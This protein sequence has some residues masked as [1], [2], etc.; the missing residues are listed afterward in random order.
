[1]NDRHTLSFNQ[2]IKSSHII[3]ILL[4]IVALIVLSVFSL[5]TIHELN[6]MNE[7]RHI[8][9]S[10]FSGIEQKLT[11]YADSLAIKKELQFHLN[12][13]AQESYLVISLIVFSMG[14]FCIMGFYTYRHFRK[15][16][17]IHFNKALLEELLYY[18][19]L[20]EREKTLPHIPPSIK[21]L[22]LDR[23]SFISECHGALQKNQFV[24][25]YQPIINVM[26]GKIADV[27][28][29]IRWQ[30]P[31]YGVLSPDVFLPLCENSEFII[32]LGQW[33]LKKAFDQIKQWQTLG[34]ST[35][36]M[37]INLSTRQ[38]ID[39]ELPHL[40]QDIISQHAMSPH[41]IKLE[42]TE[43][44]MMKDMSHSIQILN[45]LRNIGIQLSLDD[46]GTGYATL[47]YLKQLPIHNIK[48]DKAFIHDMTYNTTSFEI[49]ES[50]IRLAKNLGLTITAE[51]IENI[52]QF[53]LLK[54]MKCDFVQGY[55]YSK[56]IP[57]DEFTQ[58]LHQN[59]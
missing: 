40:I 27:E 56:P 50:V 32:P 53:Q 55:L 1:M 28:A 25:Y 37:S 49:V 18:D 16:K 4:S 48:I 3:N 54:K 41:A 29:L 44:L 12:H 5:L 34:F 24:L 30:H 47:N 14:F 20:N 51:G 11:S 58:L 2:L 52:S 7:I 19:Q 39:P 31:T 9:E 8:I 45:S 22:Q 13:H 33:I 38:L 46:F 59:G 36:R 15:F 43:S 35:L 21:K 57:H 10:D 17:N 42:I 26:T 23:D 6:S